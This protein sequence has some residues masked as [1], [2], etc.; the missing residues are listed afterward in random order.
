MGDPHVIGPRSTELYHEREAVLAELEKAPS[1]FEVV[2]LHPAVLERYEEQLEDLQHALA[3]GIHSGDPEC[4][5]A[6]QELVETVAVAR[7]S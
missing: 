7:A 4:A 3:D 6:I 1:A 5:K 2:S